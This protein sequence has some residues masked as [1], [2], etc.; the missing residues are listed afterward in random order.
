M[1]RMRR[2]WRRP[3]PCHW[4]RRPVRVWQDKTRLSTIIFRRHSGRDNDWGWWW[5]WGGA[6]EKGH[7]Y[8]LG[9]VNRCE[10][11]E[12]K[13]RLNIFKQ[14]KF[15]V[16]VIK[17]HWTIVSKR[18]WR[19]P[20]RTRSPGER[21]KIQQE[22]YMCVIVGTKSARVGNPIETDQEHKQYWQLRQ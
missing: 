12:R 21:S 18:C 7:R 9:K 2:C 17:K 15:K 10:F 14:T 13:T 16:L 20:L 1:M 5:W 6:V 3:L 22:I 11:V 4:K 19:R 8:I